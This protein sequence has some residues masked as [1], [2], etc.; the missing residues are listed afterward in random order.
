MQTILG[1]G[2]GIGV[3][4]SRELRTYTDQVRL[5][6]RNPKIIHDTDEL[7]PADLS[8]PEQIEKAVAGS[9]VVY[10][11][12][13]FEYKLSVWQKTWPAFMKSVI[14]A[15]KIH[16]SKLVFFDNVYAYARTAI[17]HMTEESLIQP[18][19]KKGMV[20]KQLHEMIMDEVEKGELTALIARGAD[21]YGPEN[22]NSAFS[23]MVAE[24][25]LKGKKAQVMG[26][27]DKV[28]NY[29]FT[30][31]AAKATA[32]LGNTGD[33]YNQVWHVPTTREKWTNRQWIQA[34]ADEVKTKARIQPFPVWMMHLLGLF[35][36]VMKELPEMLYQYDQDYFFDSRKFEQRFGMKPTPPE[37]GIKNLVES[38]RR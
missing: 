1:S 33:A 25:L 2:G 18:P 5:V 17:P 36:P 29:T 23:I 13:G 12:V 15:C 11:V 24:N 19:S 30:P 16:G 32:L 27:P 34:V 38:L 22:K 28:H 37:E 20:R 21:F 8:D 35:M 10:V 14:A 7:F 4:L 26:N 9:E 6:S 31:D 3:P